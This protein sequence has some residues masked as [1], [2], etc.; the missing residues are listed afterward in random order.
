MTQPRLVIAGTHSGVGKTTVTLALLAALAARGRRVQPFKVGPDFIDPGH[1]RLAAGRESR[2]LDGWMLD[3]AVNRETFLRA[4][5]GAELSVIEG[6][7]G[8]YDGSAPV[9]DRGSTAE[10]AK[11]LDAPVLLVMDGSGMARSAAAMATGYARFDPKVAVAG[12]VFNRVNSEGHY[13]LLKA[14][15][16]AATTL[17]VAGY[18][19][20]DSAFTIG[21]RHLG[22]IM[23]TEGAAPDIYARL[24]KAA[25]ETIDLDLVQ[26]LARSAPELSARACRQAS[27]RGAVARVA[28]A[29][30]AVACDPAFCFYYPDNLELLQAMGA[31][32]TRFSPI[33]DRVLP[34]TDLLYLGGGY[35]ELHGA[36]LSQN[37]S[38][39]Q[40]IHAFAAEG[41]PIY[42]ECGGL[43][44][45]TEAIHDGEGQRQPMVGLFACETVMDKSA[46]T[47]GYREIELVRSSILGEPGVVARGHEFHY[48][49]LVSNGSLEYGVRLMDADHRARGLDG[50]LSGN[51]LA[52]YTHL[53]FASQPKLAEALV[54][55]ARRHRDCRR[56]IDPKL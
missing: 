1:H 55:A 16:E 54:E 11:Q 4:S 20:T 10:M 50:L 19:R 12:V 41:G 44:Y 40:S 17:S 2:N 47:L 5:A 8:L 3:E 23:A 38:M 22:L 30:V 37:V 18:L 29:R 31:E 42:A 34:E 21:D 53:H 14:A 49:R 9:T 13:R 15:V 35:P 27:E 46:F 24:G 39:R 45:L 25:A 28:V 26:G 36:A 51:T 32:V 43:M 52:L 48:S 33:H 56:G 7:M 6:M